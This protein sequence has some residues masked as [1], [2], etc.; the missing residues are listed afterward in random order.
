MVDEIDQATS[1]SRE[2]F[3]DQFRAKY[4]SEPGLPL[5]MAAEVASRVTFSP[6]G[7]W[8]ATSTREYQ[9]WETGSWQPKGPPIQGDAVPE[10][11]SLAFNSDGRLMAITRD[12]NKVQLLET[13]TGE[14]V[15]TLESPDSFILSL[16]RFSPDN[17]RLAATRFDGQIEV[18]DLR[19]IRQEL[20]GM[21]LDW[22]QPPYPPA[23]NGEKLKPVSV[24]I[25]P[26]TPNQSVTK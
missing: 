21:Q 23:P 14:V 26:R 6:D 1:R 24:R 8:L 18:W 12:R 17:T 10:A 2:P 3:V 11:N 25:D 19:M 22:D 20:A 15:A 9:L 13:M 16:L 4:T 7:R 5:W